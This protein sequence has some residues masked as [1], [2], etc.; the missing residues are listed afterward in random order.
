MKPFRPLQPVERQRVL[1]ILHQ[2]GRAVF[3]DLLIPLDQVNRAMGSLSALSAFPPDL[4]PAEVI[5]A[6]KIAEDDFDR[7]LEACGALRDYLFR[8]E[9]RLA[10]MD[11]WL[12]ERIGPTL[13]LQNRSQFARWCSI[14]TRPTVNIDPREPSD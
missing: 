10:E 6:S 14:V 12:R 3:P 4:L 8:N 7:E 11:S 5:Q 2:A 13:R 9:K 1:S